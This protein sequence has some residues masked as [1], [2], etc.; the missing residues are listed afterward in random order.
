M[1]HPD[2]WPARN[3]G[4][5]AETTE[6]LKADLN[7][8]LRRLAAVEEELHLRSRE[9]A[10]RAAP[11]HDRQ[12]YE[13]LFNATPDGIIGADVDTKE[14][15]LVNPAICQMLGYTREELTRMTV[16]DV[17]PAEELEGALGEFEA[18]VKGEKPLSRTVP[19]KRK[20]DEVIY[21]DINAAMVHFQGRR[22]LMAFVRDITERIKAEE[23][24]RNLNAR[25]EQRVRERTAELEAANRE[26]E[27]FCSSVSHDLRAP[28]RSLA[29]FSQA[30]MED[31]AEVLDEESMDHLLRIQAAA[32]RMGQM[33]DDLLQLSRVTRTEMRRRTVD[34]SAMA[35][36]VADDLQRSDSARRVEFHIAED[37]KADGD[38]GLLQLVME[39]LLGNAWKF[40]SLHPRARIEFGAVEV[41][42]DRRFFVRDDGAGFDMAY[43]GKLFGAF[44]RLHGRKEFEGTGIGLATVQRIVQR[45]GGKVWAEGKVEEG[46]T[47]WFTL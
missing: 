11:R 10:G 29:G 27:A 17:H 18:Q 28:L 6:Q 41:D 3:M 31:A 1:D 42:G 15:V 46:A 23:A 38:P 9:A 33:I 7:A 22:L 14:L 43:A 44:Q 24:I 21:S 19:W 25:L 45:H 34:L 4:D 8:A 37:L 26:L 2:P 35:R 47:V 12:L 16:Y 40:T 13:V 5:P 20:N 30:L 39:N 32:K 36:Q